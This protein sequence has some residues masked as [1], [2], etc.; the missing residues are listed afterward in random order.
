MLSPLLTAETL[1]LE[2]VEGSCCK[3]KAT[4]LNFQSSNSVNDISFKGVLKAF[5]KILLLY[6]LHTKTQI[7]INSLYLKVL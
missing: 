7:K 4:F 5:Q 2:K 3:P 1:I 6:N